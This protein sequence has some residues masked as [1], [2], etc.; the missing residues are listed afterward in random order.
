VD[1]RIKTLKALGDVPEFTAPKEDKDAKRRLDE[2][3]KTIAAMVEQAA[4]FDQAKADMEIY[5]LQ[6]LGASA[7][8]LE[9]ARAVAASILQ[10]EAQKKSAD[11][12]RGILG[13]LTEQVI[14]F[15]QSESAILLYRL[16]KAGAT[17]TELEFARAVLASLDALRAQKEGFD[18]VNEAAKAHKE[19]LDSLGKSLRESLETPAEKATVKFREL[20]QLLGTG[21]ISAEEFSKAT[22]KMQAEL[23]GAGAMGRQFGKEM[24]DAFAQMI[25]YGRGGIQMLQ[26]LLEMIVANIL[27]ALVFKAIWKELGGEEGEEAGGVKGFLAG[28]FGGLAG[29]QHGGPVFSGMPY[30]VGERGPE[31]F[32]PGVAGTVVSNRHIGGDTFIVENHIDARGA[33]PSVEGRL[34]RVLREVHRSAVKTAAFQVRE[35]AL[36]SGR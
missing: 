29:K 21:R 8:E 9:F 35:N 36:R 27:K 25:V 2:I 26:S 3:K 6:K 18:K 10:L 15:G 22:R 30:L 1:R 20:T 28:V 16:E 19:G 7:A 34:R 32:V 11:E 13:D 5:R 4:A 12:V 33:D 14:A 23:E 17:A 31:L 24:G